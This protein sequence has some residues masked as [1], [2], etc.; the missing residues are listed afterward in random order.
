MN[1][2][3]ILAYGSLIDD[4]GCEIKAVIS[5]KLKG[6]QTPF[7]VEF[8]RS[9]STRGGAPTLVPVEEGGAHVKAV[10]LVLEEQVSVDKAKDMLWRRETN[11]VCSS[12]SYK[13]SP[14]PDLNTVCIKELRQFQNI[15]AVLYTS[16]KPNIDGLTPRKLARLA[17]DSV[18]KTERGQ[19]RDG[20]SYLINSGDHSEIRA[21]VRKPQEKRSL[22]PKAKAK[23]EAER[24]AV[25]PSDYDRFK[26]TIQRILRQAK[27]PLTW[28]E[29]KEVGDL[30]QK[31]PNNKWVKWMEEDIGPV[32][33]KTKE[34][35]IFWKLGKRG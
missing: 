21:S 32:G 30:P 25:P 4:P 5:C 11:Q 14:N 27:R 35:K 23:T 22:M 13:P 16:I 33:E 29:I 2:V 1:S 10:I 31:V 6:V 17:I 8:A 12:N 20:I 18:C 28:G 26:A 7:N 24:V 34:G 9:S 19:K 15:E 3:G